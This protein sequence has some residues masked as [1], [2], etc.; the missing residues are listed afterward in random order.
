MNY[1]RI[2]IWTIVLLGVIAAVYYFF[3]RTS[4]REFT[5]KSQPVQRGD[6][7]VTVTATG[8]INPVQTVQ[9]GTQ[10]TGTI[11]R[12]FADFNSVVKK[13]Q[14]VALID[15]TL[16]SATR[17]DADANYA[18]SQVQLTEM[19]RE[20]DRNEKLF[21][22][23][24]I[25]QSDYDVSLTNYQS[26]ISQMASL[27]AQLNRAKINLKYATIYAPINGVVISRNV[28][29]GQTVVSSFNTPT[30]FT[31][32]ND[33]SK[34]QVYA[35]VD[36]ADIGQIKVGQIA[37]FTVDAFPDEMF[38]GVISQI[39]LQPTIIQNVVNYTVIIDVSNPGMKLL[40]GLT[41][42]INVK[43]KEHKSVLKIPANALH[44]TPPKAYLES[45][46]SD[47]V[48]TRISGAMQQGGKYVWLLRDNDLYPVE[49]T[50]GLSDG[51][52]IE[53]RGAIKEGQEIV[54]AQQA[55]GQEGG[56]PKS[57]FMPTFTRTPR[58]MR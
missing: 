38:E 43:V 37:N 25:P 42:N 8:P 4:K 30:L 48:K 47:S 41:A 32:A 51:N 33:L 22:Q 6:I 50:T 35:N 28:D 2:I 7:A 12:L 56:Q 46:I 39:R 19:K 10:V 18:R 44:F 9:V 34:M 20:F 13:G 27:R 55:G 52:Y 57:P 14:V 31:I 15:T 17:A 3:I 11:A 58:G 49:I 24:V 1:K 54:L 16:L 5:W 23:G 40:P 53:V 21:K 29:V 26:A 45:G 36:E